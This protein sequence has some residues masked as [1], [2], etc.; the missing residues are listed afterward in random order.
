MILQEDIYSSNFPTVA[1]TK[2]SNCSHSFAIYILDSEIYRLNNGKTFAPILT[3]ISPFIKLSF[4]SNLII[5]CL[6]VF[7]FFFVIFFFF[8]YLFIFLFIYL[9]IFFFFDDLFISDHRH[10]TY[11]EIHN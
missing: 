4:L 5:V 7:F 11:E 1:K 8:F 3:A 9:F 6:F 2:F 10:M